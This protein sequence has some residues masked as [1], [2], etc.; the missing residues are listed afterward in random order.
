MSITLEEAFHGTARS[1]TLNGQSHRIR[2][3]PGITNGQ[4]IRIK[5]KGQP[6]PA[7]GEPGDLYINLNIEKHPRFEVTGHD[8]HT[9]LPVE[10]TTLVLGGEVVVNTVD[11]TVK[12]NLKPGTEAGKKLR[13]K[14][15]GL[16]ASGKGLPGDLY[17]KLQ[18]LVPQNFSAR[19]KELYE[20][21][22]KLRNQLP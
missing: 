10:F 9:S 12:M 7:G 18:V 4:T 2:L 8:L 16:P 1:F 13:L 17:V 3:K 14:G 19:E 21:L 20:E 15:K 22:A 5:G 6:A 11:S